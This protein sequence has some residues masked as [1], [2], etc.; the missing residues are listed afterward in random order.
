MTISRDREI[1]EATLETFAHLHDRF[2]LYLELAEAAN[3]FARA[4]GMAS[5]VVAE[6]MEKWSILLHDMYDALARI[7]AADE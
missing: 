1:Y 3:A 4:E 7:E 2:P 5:W 6:D